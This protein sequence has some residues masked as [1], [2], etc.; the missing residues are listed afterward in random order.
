MAE[1]AHRSAREAKA[2]EAR[3][4]YIAIAAIWDSLA[5][6]MQDEEEKLE[7]GQTLNDWGSSLPQDT[8]GR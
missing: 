2:P 7:F 6:A 8:N 3:D 5:E 4:M 1:R